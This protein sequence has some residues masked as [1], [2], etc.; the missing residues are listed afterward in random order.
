MI[1][2]DMKL[3]AFFNTKL[4][5]PKTKAVSTVSKCANIKTL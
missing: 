5:I 2:S 1:H 3:S 4:I